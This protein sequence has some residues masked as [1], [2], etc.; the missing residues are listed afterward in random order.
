MQ[1]NIIGKLDQIGLKLLILTNQTNYFMKQKIIK[2]L[3]KK[4]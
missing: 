1:K 4:L 2:L 3:M